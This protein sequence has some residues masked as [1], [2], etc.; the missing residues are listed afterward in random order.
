[1]LCA[2]ALIAAAVGVWRIQHQYRAGE[3]V[4]SA[5]VAGHLVSTP[6]F[7]YQPDAV[8]FVGRP[9]RLGFSVTPECSSFI[10]LIIFLLGS[11]LIASLAPRF[12]VRRI[13]TAL[14]FATLLAIFINVL[15]VGFIVTAST[16]WGRD[17]GFSLS[18]EYV[19]ST[20]TIV[21]VAAAILLYLW[22]LSRKRV[23]GTAP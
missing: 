1:M 18:H 8:V 20:I 7:A 12:A 11:A 5:W 17:L 10:V 2:L 3:A 9:V 6:I 16:E 4:A 22:L 15:R 13:L 14:V 19:G 21:G 23:T